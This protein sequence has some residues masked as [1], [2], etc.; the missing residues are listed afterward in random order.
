MY[1]ITNKSTGFIQYRNAKDA[2]DFVSKNYPFTEKYT[3]KRIR[4]INTDKIEE[5]CTNILYFL[6]AVVMMFLFYI[7]NL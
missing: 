2:A 6:S 1:K 4:V 5:V 3:L 7:V